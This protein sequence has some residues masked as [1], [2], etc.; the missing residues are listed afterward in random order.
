MFTGRLKT[1]IPQALVSITITDIF[2][3]L[4]SSSIIPDNLS[5]AIY[6]LCLL[7]SIIYS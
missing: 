3:S 7:S 2:C 6:I 1:E 4:T 5:V